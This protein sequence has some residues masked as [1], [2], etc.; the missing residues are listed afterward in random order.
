MKGANKGI[1]LEY[2]CA[3]FATE[4]VSF[5]IR[6]EIRYDVATSYHCLNRDFPDY[7]DSHDF[8]PVNPVNH[9]NHGSD[10]ETHGRASL[11]SL[12]APVWVA[13][14]TPPAP[15]GFDLIDIFRAFALQNIDKRPHIWKRFTTFAA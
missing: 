10:N 12:A 14:D 6:L 13:H 15:V 7:D 4:V 11:Q 2:V 9:I 8:N 1:R 3:P 5:M